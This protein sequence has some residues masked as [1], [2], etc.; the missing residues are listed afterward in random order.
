MSQ[1][2]H[3]RTVL[4]CL[5]AAAAST[6]FGCHDDE[7]PVDDGRAYFPQSVA[8]GDPRAT[9]VV[10]WTRM[11]DPD[12]PDTD[13]A[14][15][16]VVALDEDFK[17]RV[18]ERTGLLAQSAHDHALKVKV[19]RL[20]PRTRYYY[21]FILEKD[22]QR[23]GSPVGRTRTAP[24]SGTNTSVRFAVANCQDFRGRYYNSWHRLL[25]LDE[26]LDFVLFIGD[27]I[28]EADSSLVPS[29][30]PTRNVRFTDPGS[31]LPRDMGGGR[32]EL[33]AQS[34]SNYRDLYR[35][36]R[37][38][39]F[40]QQ[41][42]ERYPFIVTWDDHEFSNDCWDAHA[43]YTDGRT[44]EFQPERRRNAELAFFEYM[45]LDNTDAPPG[46]I[47]LEGVPR[48]PDT[49]I[50]RDFV[51]GKH[52]R[53]LVTDYR[54]HRPDHLI[55]EDAYPATVAMDAAV[56]ASLGLTEAFSA[57][58]FAYVNIGEFPAQQ[59][60][61][62]GAYV[63]L[64][65]G[66][67]LSSEEASARAVA[68]VQGNLALAYVNPVL[69]AAAQPGAGP[70]DPVGNPRG[71]AFVHMGKQDLFTSIGARNV[72]IK[73]TFDVYA[74]WRYATSGREAQDALGEAQEAWLLEAGEGA[75][76]WKVVAS[77]VSTTSM[78]W[79]LR[80]KPDV[81]PPTVRN[82]YY[83]SVDQWDG[84]PDKRR[85][86]FTALRERAGGRTLVVA[87]DIHAAFASV[88]HGVPALTAPAIASAAVQE[89]AGEA[90]EAAGFPP[91]TAVYRYVVTEQEATFRE[92]N[93]G[94]TFVDSDAHGFTV[95][96][97]GPEVVRA[98]YHLIP[99]SEVRVNY[100]EQPEKLAARF[101]RQDFL[102]RPGV[103]DVA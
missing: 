55:P 94:I 92:G 48:Y 63:Q 45:P 93:P 4:K 81:E 97:V 11:V 5:V 89:E 13:V 95:L 73:D 72:V 42:H 103:I 90:V 20:E 74:A 9:S 65:V 12:R 6:A 3:R 33:V 23:L 64:A 18:L 99:S 66:A 22:G 54:T 43:T 87:G 27:Y 67:G 47:D 102:V 78:I 56:L 91:G 101:S 62:R 51:F 57:D 21:R 59:A 25:Q 49:R 1:P 98:A 86:L 76:T 69:V 17:H 41:V 100:A 38:D 50:W 77:S 16:L 71:L 60:V 61:L 7:P 52:L 58:A 80:N 88:E 15:T 30:D 46:A 32:V 79:D 37:S 44:D 39:P 31:A 70:I 83:F 29:T 68:A 36:Y 2:L 85:E 75:Q 34:V 8:S 35:T 82:R 28:Y 26:E 19:T 10:L 24:A 96:E 40:L 14:I 84:F 53:L